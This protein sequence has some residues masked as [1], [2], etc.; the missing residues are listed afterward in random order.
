VTLGELPIPRGWEE[1][2]PPWMTGAI[3]RRHP[4]AVVSGVEVV[5]RDDGTTGAPGS[6]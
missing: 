4:D 1:I 2:T 6:G 3:R 5:L